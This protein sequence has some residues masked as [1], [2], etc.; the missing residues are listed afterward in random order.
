MISLREKNWKLS[1][2][3]RKAKQMRQYVF[4]VV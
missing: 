4:T 1:K 3:C 2:Y